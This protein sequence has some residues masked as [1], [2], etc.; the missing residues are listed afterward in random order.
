MYDFLP[1]LSVERLDTLFTKVGADIQH[2]MYTVLNKMYWSPMR[3]LKSPFCRVYVISRG[4]VS[5]EFRQGL[6]HIILKIPHKGWI[7]SMID[8]DGGNKKKKTRSNKRGDD[9]RLIKIKVAVRMVMKMTFQSDANHW[10]CDLSEFS[11]YFPAHDWRLHWD[12]CQELLS[13]GSFNVNKHSLQIDLSFKRH[14][15]K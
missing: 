12:L 14:V 10:D 2:M 1:Q 11:D 3:R 9:L 6:F 8:E 15:N 7:L 13:S 5:R 4:G